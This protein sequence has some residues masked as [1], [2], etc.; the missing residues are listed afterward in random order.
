MVVCDSESRIIRVLV[1][2]ISNDSSVVVHG[3]D[4]AREHVAKVTPR[5]DDRQARPVHRHPGAP[6]PGAVR[7]PK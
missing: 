4:P 3:I 2:T 1:D 5:S 7:G 6:E